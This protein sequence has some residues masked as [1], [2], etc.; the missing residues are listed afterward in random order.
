M[1][2]IGTSLGGCLRSLMA[3]EVSEDE[4]VFIVTRTMCPTYDRYI[5]VIKDYHSQG[6]PY[7]KDS[8]RYELSDY[9]LDDV[10]KL[11]GRLWNDGKIHQP[12]NFTDSIGIHPVSKL[13]KDIWL[14]IVPTNKNSTPAVLDAYNKYKMLNILT[15]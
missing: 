10:I 3:G 2:Y 9:K 14:E 1:N 12:R 5:D 13:S 11:A 8:H 7:S 6:N 4:V 15:K